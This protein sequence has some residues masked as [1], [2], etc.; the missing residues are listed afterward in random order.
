VAVIRRWIPWRFLLRRTARAYGL[1][2]P[3]ELLARLRRFAQPAEVQEPVELLRAGI[4]FHARGVVNSRVI[5]HNLDW[6]WPYWVEQQFDPASDSFVP[7]GFAISHVNLTHRN[8]TAV[9]LP[10]LPSYPIVDPRGL[11]TPH[12]DGWSLD[13]WVFGGGE[14]LLPSRESAAVQSLETAGGLA[15][16]TALA[17]S[18]LALETT[19]LVDDAGGRPEL[20]VE[21]RGSCAFPGGML[22]VALRP[23]NPEGVQFV[24]EAAYDA[25]AGELKVNG[26][27]RV[28]FE[29]APER[30]RFSTY[31]DGD[32]LH[33]LDTGDDGPTRCPTGMVTAAALFPLPA[34]GGGPVLVRVPLKTGRRPAPS[35]GPPTWDEAMRGAAALRVPDGRYVRLY[36][37]ALRT[38]V[39]L[40][41]G[42]PVPG[43][44]TYRRFWFR[45]ACLMLEALLAAGLVDRVGRLLAAFPGRQRRSGYFQSQ[46]GEWDSNGQVLW[47]CD[48]YARCG[49]R[50][51]PESLL[52]ACLRGARWIRDKRLPQGGGGRH[53]GLLPAGFSAEHFGPNDYYYWDDFWAVAGLRAAARM[54]EAWRPSA[55]PAGLA[56]CA[57][58]LLAAVWESVR[59]IPGAGETGVI[60]A[61]PYRRPDAGAV[62]SL[63]ADYPL[64]L[65]SPGDPR[66]GRT[67][68]YLLGHC[69]HEGGFFQ[70]IIH[71]GINAYLTL[72]VAQTLL[73]RGDARFAGLVDRVAVLASPTGQWPEAIHPRTGGGCMG[74]G[75]H[76][77][78]AAEWVVMM[79]SLFVRE[80]D[81]GLV[82]GS[83]LPPAWLGAAGPREELFFGPT[84]TPWGAVS[85]RLRPDTEGWLLEVDGE[86]R[87][88]PAPLEVAVA[89]HRAEQLAG[90]EVAF[91][92][93]QRPGG[94]EGGA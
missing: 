45:D 6:A 50:P 72:A 88:G 28:V 17:S 78:A 1:I 38:L 2:D 14:R 51:L 58:E 70:D 82:V 27:E 81:A 9:G 44:Y 46:R 39:L 49:G 11:V 76:G 36:D 24:E 59:A 47:I 41:A 61:S 54:A 53:G 42:E 22:A 8:W 65:T 29:P 77:W 52:D 85:V 32:V 56:A 40:S 23:F 68:E 63:A 57:A 79:R 55:D 66:I 83:G 93:V 34:A 25:R 35:S 4:V 10:G 86:W 89:G 18:G 69:F 21:V 33:R 37:A 26:A 75:Q 62:G 48:R 80:E 64:R 20:R 7:R 19:A 16:R 91:R 71:S 73:R 13:F 15:V 94:D 43:P 67:V 12:F 3:L 92:L 60:P 90:R 74:D 87:D 5:Q 84:P 30:V 31:A